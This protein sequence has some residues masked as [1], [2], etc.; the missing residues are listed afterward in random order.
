MLKAIFNKT[1]PMPAAF[2]KSLNEPMKK[3][4]ATFVFTFALICVASFGAF[5]QESNSHEDSPFENQNDSYEQSDTDTELTPTKPILIKSDSIA[6]KG[7][8]KVKPLSE[9]Q[10]AAKK[11]DED[12]VSFN[13]LYYVIQRFK[14]SDIVKD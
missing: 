4:F 6:S 3:L 5:A 11:P 13:F 7:L 9:T 1:K 14:L 2:K 12:A 8:P 10:K